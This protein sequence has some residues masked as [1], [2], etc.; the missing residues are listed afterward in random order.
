LT[1]FPRVPA[2]CGFTLS[3]GVPKLVMA[4]VSTADL[5]M[6]GSILLVYERFADGIETTELDVRFGSF[7]PK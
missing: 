5:S 2:P 7:P 6:G 4:S 3:A 1:E